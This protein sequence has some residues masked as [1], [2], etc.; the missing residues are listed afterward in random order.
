MNILSR[1]D[2]LDADDI[3]KEL[4][5]VPEWGGAVYVKGLSG[6]A[7]GKYEASIIAVHGNKT[8][9]DVEGMRY[10]MAAITICDEDGKLLFS[11][12]DIKALAEKSAAALQRIFDV[13]KRLSKISDE[14]VKELTEALEANPLEDSASD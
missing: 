10:K 14:D 12:K 1:Q 6:A 11:D 2:I 4:V 5:E 7:R 8:I 3:L 13:A 9:T